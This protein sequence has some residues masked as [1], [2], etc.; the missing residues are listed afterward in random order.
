MSF[1]DDTK[2]AGTLYLIIGIMFIIAGIAGAFASD[3]EDSTNKIL[4]VVDGLISGFIFLLFGRDIRRGCATLHISNFF[5]DL[6]SKFGVLAGSVALAGL[7]SI[8]S[9]ICTFN[10][11]SIVVGLI[12]ILFAYL[13]LDGKATISD[14]IIWII[15]LIVFVLGLIGSLIMILAIIG[16]PLFLLHLLLLV[17]LFSPEVKTKMGM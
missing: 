10:P 17:Y 1:F 9:G 16:I 14:K 7:V 2:N 11:F 3:S 5:D 12:I 13:M 4:Y 15:L 8:I 6:I